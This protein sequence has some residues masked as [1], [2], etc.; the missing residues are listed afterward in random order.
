[1]NFLVEPRSNL[2]K[3]DPVLDET[4]SGV[5]DEFV[6]ELCA[7]GTLGLPPTQKDIRAITPLFLLQKPGQADQWRVLGDMKNG[8]Q[9]EAIGKDKIF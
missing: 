5:A 8:G 1:M 9:N 6:G 2:D 4:Q 7:L 3:P